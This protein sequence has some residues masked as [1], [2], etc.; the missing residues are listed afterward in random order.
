[1]LEPR[2]TSRQLDGECYHNGQVK[3]VRISDLLTGGCT[4]DTLP[5]GAQMEDFVRLSI[6]QSI[7]VN[8]YVASRDAAGATIR[9][10]G[11]IHPFVVNRLET[12]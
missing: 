5:L 11:E 6:A 3:K 1:M 4:V 9:F 12:R 10:Y 8:G 2:S 7:Q